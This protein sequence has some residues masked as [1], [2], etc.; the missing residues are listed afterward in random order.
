MSSCN[1]MQDPILLAVAL[2]RSDYTEFAIAK[3]VDGTMPQVMAAIRDYDGCVCPYNKI[4]WSPS[5]YDNWLHAHSDFKCK[6]RKRALERQR[7]NMR[8]RKRP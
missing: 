2:W 6:E 1:Y 3:A 8:D 4:R 5:E 7:K